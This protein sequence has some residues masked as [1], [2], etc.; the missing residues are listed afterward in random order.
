MTEIALPIGDKITPKELTDNFIKAQDQPYGNNSL[1]YSLLVPNT[2]NYDSSLRAETG[3]L[4]TEKLKPL[5]IFE[6]ENAY[7]QLQAIQLVRE[8]SAAHWLRYFA[9]TTGRKIIELV[10]LSPLFSDT[11]MTFDI[12]GHAFVGRLAAKIDGNRLF[13]VFCFAVEEAYPY[14]EEVFGLA[15]SSF[16]LLNPSQQPTIESRQEYKLKDIVQF[17][18]PSSWQYNYPE[19]APVGKHAIDLYNFDDEQA[20]QGLI[21]VKAVLKSVV[22]NSD[23]LVKDTII[24]FSEA[25]FQIQKALHNGAVASYSDQFQDGL[26]MIYLGVIEGSDEPQEFWLSVFEAQSHYIVLSLLSPARESVFYTWAFNK[27]AYEI[28]LESLKMIEA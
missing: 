21:R 23:Q 10:E 4:N 11:L 3:Y 20:L 24:E 2:W 5:A 13:L 7:I 1:G 26:L 17:V 12:E 22:T 27:R 14:L 16:K 28:V 18:C 15:I 19:N 8:V 9:V 6:K 25:N